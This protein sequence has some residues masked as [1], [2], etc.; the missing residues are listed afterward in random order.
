M[1]DQEITWEANDGYVTG[2]RPQGTRLYGSD[3]QD[4]DTEEEVRGL[5]G[6]SIQE[7]FGQVVSPS[8]RPEDEDK[9]VEAWKAWK[10]EHGDE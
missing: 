8:W 2:A 5:I 9:I 7:D 1:E 6:D 4:C 10:S 3:L